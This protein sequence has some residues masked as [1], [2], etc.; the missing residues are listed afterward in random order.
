MLLVCTNNAN[1]LDAY[2][3]ILLP[4][5]TLAILLASVFCIFVVLLLETESEPLLPLNDG[6]CIY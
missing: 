1:F 4:M 3:C 5:H 2:L 6:C